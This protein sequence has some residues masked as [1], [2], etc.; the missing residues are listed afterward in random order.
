VGLYQKVGFG[1][2]SGTGMVGESSGLFY[3]NRRWSDHEIAALSFGYNIA[4]STAQ[5]ARFYAMLGAGGVNRPLTVLKQDSIPEGERIFQ[6]ED[7]EAV[8]HMMESV[9]EEG[10]TARRVKVDGYRAAGKTGTSKKA[11]AGG[12]G[13]EYVGYFAGVAPASNPRL[14]VVVLINEPGGDVY[15]GGATA[16]PAFA[17]I[18][19]NSL[20]IL[21]VAPD[22]DSVAYVKGKDDGA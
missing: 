6:Q 5:M 12:Y 8:V 11:A 4:V 19:S 15:Y 10:G 16:G 18:I 7:V 17:E 9:F 2:D 1:S 20:R 13:D 21:N 14:A 22:K 3:P